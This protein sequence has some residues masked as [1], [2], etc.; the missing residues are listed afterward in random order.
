MEKI[1]K[2]S[3]YFWILFLMVIICTFC[4]PMCIGDRGLLGCFRPCFSG[5]LK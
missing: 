5:F 4:H 1:I 3:F 2:D